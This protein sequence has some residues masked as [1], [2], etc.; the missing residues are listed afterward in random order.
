MT[1]CKRTFECLPLKQI[2]YTNFIIT[3]ILHFKYLVFAAILYASTVASAC[4]V[5]SRKLVLLISVKQ[6]PSYLTTNQNI[7]VFVKKTS[8]KQ[9]IYSIAYNTAKN[10]SA[11]RYFL[12]K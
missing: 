2:L 8:Y 6:F 7:N 1:A 12:K 3:K 5:G 11:K 10:Y 9:K 4:L